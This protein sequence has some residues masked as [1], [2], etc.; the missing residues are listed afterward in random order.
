MMRTAEG[1]CGLRF[2]GGGTDM[3]PSSRGLGGIALAENN[4]MIRLDGGAEDYEI[5]ALHSRLQRRHAAMYGSSFAPSAAARFEASVCVVDSAEDCRA[6]LKTRRAEFAYGRSFRQLPSPQ[7]RTVQRLL[8]LYQQPPHCP[9]RRH[10][11]I[12]LPFPLQRAIFA[13]DHGHLHSVR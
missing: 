7:C 1:V 11:T 9:P 3:C 13:A 4:G 12:D 5:R 6:Q 2:G 10:H 8:S